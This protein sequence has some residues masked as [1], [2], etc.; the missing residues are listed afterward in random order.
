MYQRVF[1]EVVV[2]GVDVIRGGEQGKAEYEGGIAKR[3]N[4]HRAHP[5]GYS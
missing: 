4:Q 1:P 5:G 2:F 3:R